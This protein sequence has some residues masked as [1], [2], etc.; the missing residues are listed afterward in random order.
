MARR[1][2]ARP[3]LSRRRRSTSCTSARSRRK[4][5]TPPPRTARLSG[6]ARRDGD[7]ADAGR[8][9]A[10]PLELGL[11]RR[12]AVRAA[13]AV[14][15]PRGSEAVRRRRARTRAH[16]AARR[17]LQ[18]LRSR[19]QLLA[20][21]TRSSSS[22]RATR[23]RGATRSTSTI[24]S[25]SVVRQFFIHN[26]LYWLEEYHFDGLRLDAVHAIVD[27]SDPSFLR[28][29]AAAVHGMPTGRAVHLV[30]ENDRNDAALLARDVARPA[31]RL[32]GAMERRLPSRAARAADGRDARPL[33]RLRLAGRAAA[34]L[35]AR[36]LRVPGRALA[37]SRRAARQRERR[38]AARGVREFPP[39]PRPDRQ[40]A[41]RRA[42]VDAAR[43]AAHARRRNAARAAA[44]ADPAVHGRRVP[45]A[46]RLP[47]LLRLRGRA[48]A[49]RDR[50][51][52][53][54]VREP[55]AR[56]RRRC[57]CRVPRRKPPA[58]RLFSTG[59]RVDARAA[60]GCARARSAPLRGAPP[61]ARAAAAC[62][63]GRRR[64]CSGRRR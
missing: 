22:R 1:R 10:R 48:R 56:R 61:R 27:D 62:A 44:D 34:A 25:S 47:V 31:A 7:R 32:H 14:R 18:P 54:R 45:R 19:R 33:C 55:L 4:A 28:E 63:R 23:R 49:R 50:R 5:R 6:C 57:R 38:A 11:R 41:R 58:P 30:L 3:P 46:E 35:A 53:R 59:R 60:Q 24:T 64:R 51:P 13:R 39:E 2:L 9:H 17:R 20:A 40:P 43:P 15:P 16:G 26:A 42:H 29:L 8:R 37:L 52:A 36:R 21:T 12:P